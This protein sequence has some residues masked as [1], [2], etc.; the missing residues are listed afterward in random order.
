MKLSNFSEV[1][2]LVDDEVGFDTELSDSVLSFHCV[3]L[4]L[5]R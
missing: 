1:T 4:P 2:Q 5:V 3:A